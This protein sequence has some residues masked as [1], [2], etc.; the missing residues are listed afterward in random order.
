MVYL[1]TFMGITCMTV[2]MSVYILSLHNRN[3]HRSPS[4]FLKWVALKLTKLT[5]YEV[6]YISYTDNNS[7]NTKVNGNLKIAKINGASVVSFST[8]DMDTGLYKA[9]PTDLANPMISVV[10]ILREHQS[11]ITQEDKDKIVIREWREI[12]A[13]LDDFFFWVSFAVLVIVTPV[14]LGIVPL[15]APSPDF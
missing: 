14:L 6:R 12:A 13:I 3:E 9:K 8:Q 11:R 10:E 4:S 7:I 5:R 15:T 1:I 2:G